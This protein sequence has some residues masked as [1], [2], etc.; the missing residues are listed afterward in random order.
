MTTRTV[1][2]EHARQRAFERYGLILDF[3]DL[4][5]IAGRCATGMARQGRHEREFLLNWRGTPV[6]VIYD[7]ELDCVATF[8]EPLAA[9]RCG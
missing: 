5:R 2:Q 6:V 4:R 3:D 8:L 1:R 9:W 7:A